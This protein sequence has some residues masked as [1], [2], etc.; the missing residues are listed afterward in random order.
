MKVI[1]AHNARN[2]P[3]RVRLDFVEL[4]MPGDPLQQQVERVA[5]SSTAFSSQRAITMPTTGSTNVHPVSEISARG[6]LWQGVRCHVQR[7]R[8]ED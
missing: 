5:I 2:R 6:P 3:N 1:H 7:K 8:R 4:E